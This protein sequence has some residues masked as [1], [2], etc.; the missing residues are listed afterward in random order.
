MY[1]KHSIAISET[2]F[3]QVQ[4]RLLL[5]KNPYEHTNSIAETIDGR[6]RQILLNQNNFHSKNIENTA[7]SFKKTIV[8]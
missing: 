1:F 3:S 8:N 6:I 4:M 5:K 2:L 7:N